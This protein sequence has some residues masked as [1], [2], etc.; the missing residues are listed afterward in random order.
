MGPRHSPPWTQ[1]SCRRAKLS[2]AMQVLMF[3]V[4]SRESATC[5]PDRGSSPAALSAV[6][7]FLQLRLQCLTSQSSQKVTPN[8]P[9]RAALLLVARDL[10]AAKSRPFF[11]HA[12]LKLSSSI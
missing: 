4:W 7:A 6:H 11:I 1:A 2:G 5:V 8:T 12:S 10:H 9:I 3:Q